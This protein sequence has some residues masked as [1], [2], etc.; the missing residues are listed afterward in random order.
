MVLSPF[1]QSK[2]PSQL[3]THLDDLLQNLG[4]MNFFI[5]GGL[6]VIVSGRV[7]F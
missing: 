3:I 1:E 6:D 2:K 4:P 7:E 5:L